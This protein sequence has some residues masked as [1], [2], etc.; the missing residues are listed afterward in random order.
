MDDYM[1]LSGSQRRALLDQSLA[2][3]GYVCCICG[4]SIACGDESLQH[5]TPR[6]KGGATTLENTRPAHKRCNYSLQDREAEG[7]AAVVHSGLSYF[8]RPDAPTNKGVPPR[9]TRPLTPIANEGVPRRVVLIT[10]PPGAGKSTRAR[11]LE[12]E[13]GLKVY[14]ADDAQWNGHH[15]REYKAALRQIGR[16]KT[17]RAAVIVSGATRS[18][19]EQAAR[20]IDATEIE[21][22]IEPKETL[23]QRIKERKQKTQTMRAQLAALE[24]WFKRHEE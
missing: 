16:D 3:H 13:D 10:G 8:T 17:A 22:L 6:S 19:R 12:R 11:E 18:A 7:I 20:T 2:L 9:E 14:D 24:D 23:K 4:L 15:G 5:L 21:T 1:T